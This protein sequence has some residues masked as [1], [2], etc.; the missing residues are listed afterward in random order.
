MRY[1][2]MIGRPAGT[3]W[4]RGARGVGQWSVTRVRL[5]SGAVAL[6][7]IAVAGA[8]G[9][10]MYL[11]H[12]DGVDSQLRTEAL[13]A[14]TQDVPALLSY[15]AK[16]IDKDFEDK[17]SKVTGSFRTQFEELSKKTIIPAAKEQDLTTKAQVATAGVTAVDGDSVT[18]LLFVNQST[19]TKNDP[20]AR[21]DGSRVQVVMTKV[22]DGWK[23]AGLTPV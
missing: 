18:L 22:D 9:Y 11:N 13:A 17:Y 4:R 1:L 10:L 23:V 21:L 14:G 2:R 20:G 15:Q 16:N 19:T 5:V 7:V 6:L 8:C 3:V 12:E